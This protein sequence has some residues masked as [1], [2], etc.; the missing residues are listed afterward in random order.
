MNQLFNRL[1]SEY[2]ARNQEGELCFERPDPLMVASKTP[3]ELVAVVCALYA[4]G[5]AGQI[6]K[7]LQKLEWGLLNE[8]EEAIRKGLDGALYRFQTAADTQEFFI[9]LRRLRLEGGAQAAF[10]LGYKKEYSVID[11]LASLIGKLRDLNAHT[12]HG[13][14][15]LI[16]R[17]PMGKQ[18]ESPLK[19]WNLFLRWMVRRD[20]LDMGLWSGVERAHLIVPLD[21]HTCAVGKRLGLLKRKSYDLGAAL[22]LTESL[23]AFDPQDPVKYDFALYRIGQEKIE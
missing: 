3:D 14:D 1:E 13:Y 18:N 17:T 20:N 2:A 19:R 15:F 8:S 23:R 11:G 16:G 22:E 5:N 7:F 21:T 10:L 6:V 4:Y 9:T 12:S